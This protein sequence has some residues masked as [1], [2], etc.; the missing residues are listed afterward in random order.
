MDTYYLQSIT[1]NYCVASDLTLQVCSQ[2]TID[3]LTY[4]P[5]GTLSSADSTFLASNLPSPPPPP[6]PILGKRH[7]LVASSPPPPFPPGGVPPQCSAYT[8]VNDTSREYTNNGSGYLCDST[9]FNTS[10]WYAFTDVNGYN[11]I[12]TTSVNQNKCGTQASGWY[13]GSVPTLYQTTVAN[14]CYNWGSSTCNWNAVVYATQCNGFIIYNFPNG[15]TGGLCNL[16]VCTSN[17]QPVGF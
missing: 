4:N 14:M 17:I 7:L 15:A 6:S 9:Y 8:T 13:N 3:Y 11:F 12:P 1:T 16:R 2:P 10:K 5:N